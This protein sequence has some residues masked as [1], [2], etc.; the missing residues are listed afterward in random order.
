MLKKKKSPFLF[1]ILFLFT[2]YM[3]CSDSTECLMWT[4]MELQSCPAESWCKTVNMFSS[5]REYVDAFCQP[6]ELCSTAIF[7][8]EVNFSSHARITRFDKLI[9]S[10]F[11]CC[12]ENWLECT[13]STLLGEGL[14]HSGSASGDVCGGTHTNKL[15]VC[16]FLWGVHTLCLDSIVSPVQLHWVRGVCM[17]SCNLICHLHFWWNNRGLGLASTAVTQ[18]WNK[19]WRVGTEVNS[20]ENSATGD[21]SCPLKH[22]W[23]STIE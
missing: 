20:W 19:F 14:V 13:S 4:W 7:M 12:W 1:W 15:C 8:E 17:S 6:V 16:S 10:A 23:Y 18:G 22:V 9:Q 11:F 3:H 2:N 5:W 21:R